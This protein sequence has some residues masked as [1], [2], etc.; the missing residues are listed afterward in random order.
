MDEVE[1]CRVRMSITG[2]RV[3][4]RVDRSQLGRSSL[5]AAGRKEGGGACVSVQLRQAKAAVGV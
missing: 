5:G 3:T 2:P 4:V 1:L